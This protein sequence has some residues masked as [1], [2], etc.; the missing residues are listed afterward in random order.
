MQSIENIL[1]EL[2]KRGVRKTLAIYLSS[3]LTTIGVARLFS[4]TYGLPESI[5]PILVAV[6]TFGVANAVVFAWFHGAEGTQRFRPAEIAIHAAILLTASG[7]AFTVGSDSP[8]TRVLARD[9]TIAVLPFKNT[10]EPGSDDYFSDGI[11]EDILTQL[12][13]IRDLA[14][15]ARPTVMTYK[16]SDKPLREIADEL[17]ATVLLDGTIRQADNRVRIVATLVDGSTE[18]QLWAEKYDREL[19]DIFAIQS[20]VA[21]R[22]ADALRATLL[23][24]EKQ[25]IERPATKSLEAYGFYLRGREYY[26]RRTADD[27]ERAIELLKKAIAADPAYALAYA[28]LADAYALRYQNFGFTNEWADSSLVL[29]H[30]AVTLDPEIPEPYK[31]LGLSYYQNERY[32]DAAEAYRKA[33]DLNP[34]YANVLANLG[35]LLDYS[36]RADEAVPLILRAIT[37]APD[38]GTAY[39]ILGTACSTLELDTIATRFFHKAKELQPTLAGPYVGLSETYTIRRRPDQARAVLDTMRSRIKENGFLLMAAGNVELYERKYQAAREFFQRSFDVSGGEQ[40]VELLA[41]TM[42]KTDPRSKIDSLLDREEAEHL[43]VIN[44]GSEDGIRRYDLAR[45]RAMRNDR[46][47][48]LRW[49]KE[50]FERGTYPLRLIETDP[51][52][53]SMLR[54]PSFQEV[55]R[56]QREKLEG[57]RRGLRASETW[58]QLEVLSMR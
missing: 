31:S 58:S 53:E 7:V 47:G 35:E 14:V 43:A 12:S 15:I 4:E 41:F 3:A 30:Y 32:A 2:K 11:T 55:I 19:K 39:Q 48:T 46:D 25:R 34:S 10:G 20:D 27:N 45:I 9:H 52:M 36:G 18:Q 26:Y 33:L 54:D 49:F 56:A 5:T 40:S 6:L 21:Q 50:A 17:R 38:R 23:P 1:T 42:K 24:E 28:G 37:L 22:I 8:R 51:L 44:E 13:K 16:G 29:S 57:M